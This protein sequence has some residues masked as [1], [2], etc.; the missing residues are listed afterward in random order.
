MFRLR[1]LTQQRIDDLK[2]LSL[3]NTIPKNFITQ[4]SK[5]LILQLFKVESISLATQKRW[6]TSHVY[7]F[8]SLKLVKSGNG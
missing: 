4:K 2:I 7:K 3:I 6:E 5:A 8:M 1:K